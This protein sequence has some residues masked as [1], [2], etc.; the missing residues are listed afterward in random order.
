MSLRSSPAEFNFYPGSNGV[1]KG[2]GRGSFFYVAGQGVAKKV[3]FGGVGRGLNR[4][5][6]AGPGWGKLFLNWCQPPTHSSVHSGLFFSKKIVFKAQ[7][8]SFGKWFLCAF[9]LRLWVMSIWVLKRILEKSHFY[10]ATRITIPPSLL[11][12]AV[13]SQMVG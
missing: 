6:G 2:N 13:Q 12:A 10:P 4:R 5:G 9:N 1:V 7:N 11:L 3:G 8:A